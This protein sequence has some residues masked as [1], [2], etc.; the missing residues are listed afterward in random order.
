MP[1][2]KRR[3]RQT[4]IIPEAKE[5]YIETIYLEQ[6][7]LG[8]VRSL[9]I[10]TALGY[11]KPTISVAMKAL[12]ENGYIEIDEGG[13]ITLTPSGI[14]IAK[15]LYDRHNSIAKLLMQIGVSEKIAYEDACKIEHDI[16]EETFKCI[17]KEIR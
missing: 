3:R 1:H 7:K 9:D 2:S 5:N 4:L 15:S 16:S 11:S 6:K 14:K 12:R 10:A 13:F 8:R 17:K